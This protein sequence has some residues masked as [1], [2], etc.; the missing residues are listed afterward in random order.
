[1]PVQVG[2]RVCAARTRADGRRQSQVS[3]L[4]SS[5]RPISLDEL[6]TSVSSAVPPPSG[7][8]LLLNCPTPLF[9]NTPFL[10]PCPRLPSLPPPSHSPTPKSS[11]ARGGTILNTRPPS[12]CTQPLCLC[13]TPSVTYTHTHTHT[14][15]GRHTCSARPPLP[16]PPSFSAAPLQPP[17]TPPRAHTQGAKHA[18]QVKTPCVDYSLRIM[19]G[20]VHIC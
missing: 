1:M 16:F 19:L 18:T 15:T 6:H 2:V 4:Y 3:P 9:P 17:P 8:P 14:H 7:L 20:A 10:P 5:N 13:C 12:C 11:H